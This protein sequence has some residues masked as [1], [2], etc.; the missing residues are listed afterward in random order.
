MSAVLFGSIGSVVETS[1]VQRAAFNEAFKRHHLTWNWSREEYQQ[2]LLQ[3]GGR[4]RI[5]IYAKSRGENVDAAGI[6]RTKSEIFQRAI[7]EGSM[8]PRPGVADLI[9]YAKERDLKVGLVTTTSRSNIDA[10]LSSVAKLIDAQHFDTIVDI[11]Q[12]AAPKPSPSCY[13]V[14]MQHLGEAPES[15]IA[16]EDNVDGVAA[17]KAVGLICIAFPGNNT[18][19]HDYVDADF[20]THG[21]SNDLINHHLL[22]NTPA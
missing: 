8:Q 21:L 3:S 4:H 16:I 15:C 12:A 19:D 10:L 22:A 13:K 14:A 7:R 20:C 11:T 9:Q 18:A 1:E 2:L 6:H 17:A 5:E